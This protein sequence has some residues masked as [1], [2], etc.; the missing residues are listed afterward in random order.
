MD[1]LS[2]RAWTGSD[3]VP[4]DDVLPAAIPAPRDAS[5]AWLTAMPHAA[6]L[7]G[8]SD[9]A[10]R[11][12]HWNAPFARLFDALVEPTRQDIHDWVA[13]FHSE[14][15]SFVVSGHAVHRFEIERMTPLGIEAFTCSLAWVKGENSADDRILVCAVDRTSDRRVEESLRRELIS[16]TLTALPNRVGFGES[17]ETLLERSGLP[18]DSWVSVLIIDLMRF[19]RI[20]EALGTMAGDELILAVA[21]RLNACVGRGIT[22]AR[23]GGNEFGIC[24]V[25]PHGIADVMS[26]ADRVKLAISSPIRLA[27]LEISINCAIGCS[28]SRAADAEADELIRQA[29]TAA[30]N[31]KKTDRL[32]VYR[33]GE[34]GAAR[35]RFM[36]ESRLRDA[37]DSGKLHLQYQPIIELS[38]ENVVGLEALARWNDADLGFVSPNDFIPVAEES[39]LIVQLGRWAVNEALQQLAQWDAHHG[40]QVPLK[41]NVNLSPI[42]MVRDDVASMVREAL[43]LS[44]VK[45]E[46]LSMEVTESALVADPDACRYLLESLKQLDISIAMDD[47]GTGYSNMASLQKLPIDVLKIDRSFVSDM[48][49]DQDKL[50]IIGAILSLSKVLGIDATAEG[51]EDAEVAAKLC[52]MGCTFGQGYYFAKPMDADDAYQFWLSR[53][54]SAA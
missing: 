25:T 32:E 6:A 20:N 28:L 42:Q 27:N 14:L 9:G 47:F 46:R 40:D 30:R 1:G 7:V 3:F 15:A 16:D 4:T 10:A 33:A 37:L 45:G 24:Q 44:G 51:I 13:G 22:L 5:P 18:D 8:W 53:K 48:L 17:I 31:A 38:S 2:A 19:S 50:A 12:E 43:R 26:L 39:G 49:V 54:N 41:I 34:L 21:A 52:E 29:Q 11:F 35:Q 36:L 23:I